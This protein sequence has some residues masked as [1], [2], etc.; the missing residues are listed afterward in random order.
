MNR[1]TFIQSSSGAVAGLAMTGV[2][3]GTQRA[4]AKDLVNDRV[5]VCVAGVGGRG[6]WA[7]AYVRSARH[8]GCE[9]RVRHR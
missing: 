5:R 9:V 8:R 4:A 1:R 3:A 6:Q 7:V 2:M